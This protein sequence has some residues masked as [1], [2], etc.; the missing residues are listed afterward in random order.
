MWG[1]ETDN[2]RTPLS[3]DSNIFASCEDRWIEP[4]SIFMKRVSTGMGGTGLMGQKCPLLSA[5]WWNQPT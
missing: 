4:D 2:S 1:C 5:C 3:G